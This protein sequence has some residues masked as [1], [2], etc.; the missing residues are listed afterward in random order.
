MILMKFDVD[1]RAH[2]Y[3]VN[4]GIWNFY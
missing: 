1:F 3:V 4:L 2:N